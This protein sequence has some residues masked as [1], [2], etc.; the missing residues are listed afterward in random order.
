[1]KSGARPDLRDRF[2][3]RATRL[4]R[5]LPKGRTTAHRAFWW[6]AG[7]PSHFLGEVDGSPF[8][9]D[10]ADTDISLRTYLW[11]EW[12]PA[13]GAIWVGLL[14]EGDTVVD[15]GA[16]KGYF[17]LLAANRI[18]HTGRVISYEPLP[19]NIVDLEA[20]IMA[21]R[22]GNWILRPVAVSASAGSAVLHSPAGV[23]ASGWGT[24][25]AH[26]H[27][28][29]EAQPIDTVTLT[30]DFTHNNLQRIDLLKMDIQGHECAALLGA[31]ELLQEGRIGALFVEVHPKIMKPADLRRMFDLMTAAGYRGRLLDESV[32]TLDEWRMLL[33]DGHP[34]DIRE[35]LS[36]IA[37]PDDPRVAPHRS[38]KVLWER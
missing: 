22:H 18:G 14:K 21:G 23:G 12:E 1:M 15:V 9:V 27:I 28:R 11:Q 17:S 7:R 16:N 30:T 25:E 36:P 32:R 10:S 31:S 3:D 29:S 4:C 38:Y 34:G 33:R 2:I 37:Q 24:L 20:T 35:L 13:A 6:V 5:C 8:S 19:R 26:A